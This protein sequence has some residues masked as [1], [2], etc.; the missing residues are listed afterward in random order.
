MHTTA[1]ISARSPEPPRQEYLAESALAEE[2]LD[3]IVETRF[4][5]ADDLADRE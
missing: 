1:G 3:S 2:T 4:R 5:A